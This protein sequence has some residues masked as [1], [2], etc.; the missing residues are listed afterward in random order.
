MSFAGH[1]PWMSGSPHGVRG[2]VH[3]PALPLAAEADPFWA[4]AVNGIVE[5]T[6]VSVTSV[7]T[8]YLQRMRSPPRTG[9]QPLW[10]A[11]DVAVKYHVLGSWHIGAATICRVVTEGQ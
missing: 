8:R 7:F 9:S 3:D 10:Q 6:A 5:T 2:A 1:S 11:P 4:A